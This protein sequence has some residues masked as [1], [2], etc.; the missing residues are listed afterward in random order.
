MNQYSSK[1]QHSPVSAILSRSLIPAPA[2][3]VIAVLAIGATT[4]L[5]FVQPPLDRA[6]VAL[7]YL[8]S[9]V[10][11]AILA[12]Y[13]PAILAALLSFMTLNY[14]FIPP[15][16]SLHVADPQSLLQLLT[17]LSVATIAGTLA[18]YARQQAEQA[19]RRV[20]ETDALYALSQQISTEVN[21]ERLLTAITTTTCQLLDIPC[22]SIGLYDAA[23]NLQERSRAGEASI[24]MKPYHVPMQDG[25]NL[26]GVM[27]AYTPESKTSFQP[28]EQRL[29]AGIAA[30]AQ[31]A[32]DRTHLAA[33]ATSAQAAIESDR[34]KSALLSSV[35]HDLRTPLTTI[36]GASSALLA[37]AMILDQQ[38]QHELMT[39]IDTETDR[40]NRLVGNWLDIARIEAGGLRLGCDWQDIAE[41]VGATVSRYYDSI[42]TIAV[43]IPADLP[44]IWANAALVD[45]VLTN[46]LEN[47]VKYSPAGT[48]ISICS[49]LASN[50]EEVLITVRDSGPGIMP[51]DRAHIFET[52]YRGRSQASRYAGSG[53]GLAICRGIIM[54]HGGRI[55][56]E[57]PADGGTAI[58]F[59]LPTRPK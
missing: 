6:T 45:Q 54:A 55:W 37:D 58:C 9:V 19:A 24:L 31:L 7:F 41:I 27:T 40:L 48:P 15:R 59:S 18:A 20:A 16:L 52:F 2:R 50:A 3:Y 21:L 17:F 28:F 57:F 38:T 14:F 26:L 10:A 30:Q 49:Q 22:C 47:A 29:L 46:L 11:V 53:L 8:L 1:T 34:L 43:H 4:L 44:L 35:S 33:Q 23:G 13:G 5:A 42:P 12:G 32:I 51:E 56:A 39:T 36:K 25:E